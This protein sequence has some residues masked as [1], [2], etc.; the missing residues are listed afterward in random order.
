MIRWEIE[1]LYD[2][3]FSYR[4]WL[5]SIQVTEFTVDEDWEGT[6]RPN[7]WY[8]YRLIRNDDQHYS[9]HS[10]STVEEAI[11]KVE[12]YVAAWMAEAGE[13]G[14]VLAGRRCSGRQGG[15]MKKP[16]FTTRVEDL[17]LEPGKAYLRPK[18][19]EEWID[20]SLV[21]RLEPVDGPVEVG[22]RIQPTKVTYLYRDG[23]EI[24]VTDEFD[25]ERGI[26]CTTVRPTM[27]EAEAFARRW[28][29]KENP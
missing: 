12:A 4:A 15:G 17:K 18:G 13:A 10:A 22:R 24:D 7:D 29:G 26:T 11:S 21:S 14:V 8:Y 6:L 25:L 3:M 27:E 23:S 9:S 2:D 28:C 19:S 1:R 5:G 20:L 16:A